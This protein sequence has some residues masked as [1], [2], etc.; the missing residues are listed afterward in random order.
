LPISV[1]AL[2][3][4]EDELLF[5]VAGRLLA[6]DVVAVIRRLRL[7]DRA[8]EPLVLV[9]RMF[10]RY[11]HQHAQMVIACGLEKARQLAEATHFVVQAVVVA[12]VVAVVPRGAVE[13]GQQPEAVHAEVVELA[14]AVGQALEIADAVAVSVHVVLNVERVD[15]AVFIPTPH[16]PLYAHHARFGMGSCDN[17]GIYRTAA[18]RWASSAARSSSLKRRPSLVRRHSTSS[19][20]IAHSRSTR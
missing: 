11:A 1:A 5:M 16:A 15:D 10:D 19:A 9:R 14:E 13:D 2:L 18:L 20:V 3:L 17:G 8:A 12:H 7:L 4:A 6:P